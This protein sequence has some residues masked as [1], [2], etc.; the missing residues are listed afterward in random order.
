MGFLAFGLP[1]VS[2]VPG[3]SSS[4]VLSAAAAGAVAGVVICE[5]AKPLCGFVVRL[6]QAA[7]KILDA[8]PKK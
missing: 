4:G 2:Q 3:V 6:A 8:E 7:K 1:F 5:C